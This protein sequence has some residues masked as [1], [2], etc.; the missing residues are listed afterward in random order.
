MISE[1]TIVANVMMAVT[2]PIA[3][4]GPDHHVN[5]RVSD[6]ENRRLRDG[7]DAGEEHKGNDE[8]REGKHGSS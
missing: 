2:M 7:H 3:V 1:N 6:G 4:L 5:L 8:D